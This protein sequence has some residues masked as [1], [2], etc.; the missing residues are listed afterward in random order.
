MRQSFNFL[1]S[2]FLLL[3][4]LGGCSS[5]QLEPKLPMQAEKIENHPLPFDEAWKNGETNNTNG[6]RVV[7]VVSKYGYSIVPEKSGK[8]DG[9]VRRYD[10]ESKQIRFEISYKMGIRDGWAKKYSPE[11]GWLY[12]AVLYRNGEKRELREYNQKGEIVHIVPYFDG[13]KHGIEQKFSYVNGELN[14]RIY[15]DHGTKKRL[16]RYCK[17]KPDLRMEMDGCRQGAEREW[18][19]GTSVLKRETPYRNCK[20]NGTEKRYDASGRLLYRVNYR[21]DLKEGPAI[22]YYSNGKIKYRLVYHQD[23]PEEI[24][25]FYSVSGKKERIDYDTLIRFTERFPRGYHNWWQAI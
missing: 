16:L 24:A 20:R 1:F 19:C 11:G 9:I 2:A 10:R 3:F 18:Y 6:Y 17:G 13:K 23:K 5:S 12:E 4:L 14:Y 7:R 25:F 8:K 21:D 15:Y 22:E